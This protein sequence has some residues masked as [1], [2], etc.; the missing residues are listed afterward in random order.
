MQ[1]GSVVMGK[2]A[3][4]VSAIVLLAAATVIWSKATLATRVT[5]PVGA[6]GIGSSASDEAGPLTFAERF[7][8]P[9]EMFRSV[10]FLQASDHSDAS[11]VIVGLGKADRQATIAECGRENWV[12]FTSECAAATTAKPE[13]AA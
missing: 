2:T 6:Y 1:T 9:A 8:T 4:T 12:Y 10:D 13:P 11:N 5:G 3:G 7:P